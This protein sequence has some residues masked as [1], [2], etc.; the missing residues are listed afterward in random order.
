MFRATACT[1]MHYPILSRTGYEAYLIANLWPI[2][3]LMKSFPQSMAILFLWS[4]HKIVCARVPWNTDCIKAS[5]TSFYNM[6]QG[7]I[8]NLGY[9]TETRGHNYEVQ[10]NPYRILIAHYHFHKL[11]TLMD[12]YNREMVVLARFWK[13]WTRPLDRPPKKWV[14]GSL[15]Q[16]G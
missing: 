3:L 6:L 11:E 4:T 5:T 10:R 9:V 2:K 16:K 13:S 8:C 12:L 14:F 7:D 1:S 15:F